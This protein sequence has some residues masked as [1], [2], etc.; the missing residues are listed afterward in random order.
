MTIELDHLFVCVAAGAPE[1]EH[2]VQFGLMEGT[3]N[4]HRGQGTANRRFFFQNAMLELLWV[5]NLIEAQS[6]QTAPTQLWERWSAR[7][8]G[9][10]PF[11]TIVRPTANWSGTLP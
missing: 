4:V 5:E 10:C 3:P 6:E 11:G 1:A 7:L 8:A 9:A 2:L